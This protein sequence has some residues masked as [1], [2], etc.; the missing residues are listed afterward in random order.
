MFVR[1][2]C[3][4]ASSGLPVM[5][6]RTV[7]GILPVHINPSCFKLSNVDI[8]LRLGEGIVPEE[9]SISLRESGVSDQRLYIC[10]LIRRQVEVF[11]FGERVQSR[12]FSYIVLRQ[13]ESAQL[14]QVAEGMY[15]NYLIVVQPELLQDSS[16]FHQRRN[17]VYLLER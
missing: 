7:A 5:P 16:Q 2:S 6:S 10:Y 11:Q 1:I 17:I 12:D 8:H 13:T 14:S 15:L 3:S 4:L 9:Q